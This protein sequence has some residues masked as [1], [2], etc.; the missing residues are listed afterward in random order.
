LNHFGALYTRKQCE[1]ANVLIVVGLILCR[2]FMGLVWES[3]HRAMSAVLKRN[4][5]LGRCILVLT[6][7]LVVAPLIIIPVA[8]CSIKTEWNG[9]GV[10]CIG[11][12]PVNVARIEL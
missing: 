10:N 11:R 12:T 4:S 8:I 3:Q 1:G 2:F 6:M 9:D 7:V 5:V